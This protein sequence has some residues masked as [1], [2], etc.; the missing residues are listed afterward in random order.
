MIRDEIVDIIAKWKIAETTR[1]GRSCR[2][3][4]SDEQL[5]AAAAAVAA[6]MQLRQMHK[7]RSSNRPACRKHF[8]ASV[9]YALENGE[10]RK[11]LLI[12]MSLA[13][14]ACLLNESSLAR[15]CELFPKS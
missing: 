13:N 7:A 4:S 5:L 10:Q 6:N 3:F 8:H 2:K 9:I 14:L 11:L 15:K 1:R 12:L